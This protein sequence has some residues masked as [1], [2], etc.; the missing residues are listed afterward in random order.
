MDNGQ[1]FNGQNVQPQPQVNTQQTQAQQNIPPQGQNGYD[2]RN[3]YAQTGHGYYQNMNAGFTPGNYV[4]DPGKGLGV[5]SLIC[6]IV[7]LFSTIILSIVAIVLGSSSKTKSARSGF[8]PQS[9]AKAGII[10]GIVG[11]IWHILVVI[12]VVVFIIIAVKN[13]WIE[14]IGNALDDIDG[15]TISFT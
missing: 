9:S 11:I 5:G 1:G 2:H 15:I 6:G 10:F 8:A 14:N 12:G 3:Q 13:G 4:Q 7:G